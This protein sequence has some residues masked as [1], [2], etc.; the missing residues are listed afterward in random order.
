ML[1]AS[2]HSASFDGSFRFSFLSLARSHL[3]LLGVIKVFSTRFF[4]IGEPEIFLDIFHSR[5]TLR[6]T[7]STRIY[8]RWHGNFERISHRLIFEYFFNRFRNGIHVVHFAGA[9]KPWQLTF[10]PQNEHLSG[11]LSGQND[12]QRDFL[13]RW[14]RIMH[15]RVW[16]IIQQFSSPS[17]K[18]LSSSSSY[19]SN[20]VRTIKASTDRWGLFYRD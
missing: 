11:N 2:Q 16:P 4:P 20:R 3:S 19:C 13:L 7:P 10:N 1:F 18:W 5:T 12:I 6:P 14:W 17:L 8:R 9:L 15:Q